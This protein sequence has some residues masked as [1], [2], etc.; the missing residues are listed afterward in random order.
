MCIYF[1]QN[2]KKKASSAFS[3]CFLPVLN[4][5]SKNID[6]HKQNW[7]YLPEVSRFDKALFDQSQEVE[8]EHGENIDKLQKMRW[9]CKYM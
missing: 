6:L 3:L 7:K 5:T 1:F 2:F 9:Y 4:M 8:K